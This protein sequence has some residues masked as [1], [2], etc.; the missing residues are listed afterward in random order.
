M[1]KIDLFDDDDIPNLSRD[2]G[3]E[4]RDEWVAVQER[5][6]AEEL[7]AEVVRAG[8]DGDAAVPGVL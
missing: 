7:A 3:G 1:I 4:R 2:D 6:P 5:G 8:E